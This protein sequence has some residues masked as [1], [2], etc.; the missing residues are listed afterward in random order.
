MIKKVP[1]KTGTFFIIQ[2][3]RIL[4]AIETIQAKLTGE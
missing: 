3:F 4:A 1:V 2:R